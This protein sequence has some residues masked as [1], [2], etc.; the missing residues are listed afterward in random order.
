MQDGDNIQKLAK[1]Y[2]ISWKLIARENDIKAPYLLE[3]GKTIKL[4][5]KNKN[6][7]KKLNKKS[8]E[9]AD[10]KLAKPIRRKNKS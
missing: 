4:L 8:T 5:M 1:E 2:N 7:S 9:K 10:S 3:P 6:S